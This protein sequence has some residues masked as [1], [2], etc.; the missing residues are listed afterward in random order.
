MDAVDAG[1]VTIAVEALTA[2]DA[3]LELARLA[4]VLG[5]ANDAYHTQDAPLMPD[6]DYDA[7]KRRNSAI[8]ARFPELKRSD[9]PSDQVGAAPAEAFGKVVHRIPMLSLANEFEADGIHE[10]NTRIRRFLNLAADAPLA[11]VA[12]PKIDGLSLSLR[13]E[14]GRLVQAATRGDGEVG[15]DVTANART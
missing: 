2:E 4:E 7:L 3:R 10:F 11:Y 12:E 13:Y 15:E 8:E 14:G 6:A 9:S 5:A 1:T